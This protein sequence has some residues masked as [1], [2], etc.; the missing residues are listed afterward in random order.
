MTECLQIFTNRVSVIFII[1]EI[2]FARN[3]VKNLTKISLDLIK[4]TK[5]RIFDLK[6]CINIQEGEPEYDKLP[7]Y[8]SKLTQGLYSSCG[9]LQYI[10]IFAGLVD[11]VLRWPWLA[12]VRLSIFSHYS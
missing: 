6:I 8:R 1:R 10:S 11:S 2:R 7:K 4:Y 9:N 12:R 3:S 5:I